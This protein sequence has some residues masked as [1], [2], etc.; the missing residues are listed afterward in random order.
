MASDKLTKLE[1]Q[2]AELQRKQDEIKA[3]IRAIKSKELAEKRKK[4]T[5]YKVLL[6]AF[7]LHSY[8]EIGE[9]SF[10]SA[11]KLRKVIGDD[12]KFNELKSFI[13]EEIKGEK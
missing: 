9:F 3:K 13:E 12:K 8:S 1:Q 11:E 7:A 10:S 4:A 5:H 6:G 2:Q